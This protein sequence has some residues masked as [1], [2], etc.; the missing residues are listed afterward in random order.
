[1]MEAKIRSARIEDTHALPSIEEEAATLFSE[2][3]ID[4]GR[5]DTTFAEKDFAAACEDGRLLV[6]EV[7]DEVV[8]FALLEDLG[9]EAYLR[10]L[11][12]APAFGHQGIGRQLVQAAFAWARKRDYH[13]MVLTTFR[14][15]PWN[16]PFYATEGFHEVEGDEALAPILRRDAE[17]YSAPRVGM[18][19]SLIRVA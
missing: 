1:M 5:E 10:E 15:P 11:D 16:A 12:V 9:D 3:G 17:R 4:L 18:R 19:K 7:D 2:A 13:S 14:E 8:G 6:A